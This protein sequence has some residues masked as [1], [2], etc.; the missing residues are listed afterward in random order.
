M[1]SFARIC[2]YLELDLDF[3]LSY[4]YLRNRC[5]QNLQSKPQLGSSELMGHRG[6]SLFTFGIE[7]R[8]D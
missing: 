5:Y 7:I 4:A 2:R 8:N 3:N 1:G 6:M